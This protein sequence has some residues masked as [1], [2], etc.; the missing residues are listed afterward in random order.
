MPLTLKVFKGDAMVA[1]KDYDRDIIKIGRL[2]SAHLCLDDDKV[3]R[4]H[5]VIEVAPDGKLSIIDMGSVEGTWVNGRRVSKG[6]LSFGDEIRVGNTLIKVEDGATAKAAAALAAAAQTPASSSVPARANGNG[7]SPAAALSGA[8]RA[9]PVASVA[10]A[11]AP[12]T[13]AAAPAPVAAP[14]A[15]APVA[16]SPAPVV[17]RAP[18]APRAAAP[19]E[20]WPRLDARERPLRR[21]G[22]GPLGLELRFRWGDQILA[23]QLLGPKHKGEFKIGSAAG[24]DFTVGDQRLG[25]PSFVLVSADGA[26]GFTLRITGQMT[27]ELERKG[28]IVTLLQAIESGI[29]TREDDA[30]N[31]ALEPDDIVLVDVGGVVVDLCF[32]PVPPK[33]LVPLTERLD[34]TALNIFLL[35]FFFAGL[36][37]VAAV[38]RAASGEEF[39]DELSGNTAV[40]T[41]LL[42][43]P[44]EMQKNPFIEQLNKAKEKGEA[45]AAF[46]G[47]EGQMGKKNAP[48]RDAKASPKAI[49]PNS[50]DQARLIAQRIFGGKGNAGIATLFGRAGL[51]GSLQAAMGHMTGSTVG[52][53]GGVLGM[54]LKGSGGGGGGTG[55]TIGIGAVGTRGVAGGEGK[56]GTGIG[57][58]KKTSADISITQSDPEVQGSMDPELIRRVVRS[59]HDQ[60]KYCYDNAL[61]RNPKLTGKVSIRWII[62]EAGTVASSNVVSSTTNT[63]DLDRCIAG[64]VLTWIFPKPK[65]GGVAVVTYP[66]VFK[67]AGE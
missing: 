64:R 45:P 62:T 52:D 26:G 40:L 55:N 14:V 6:V 24:V 31:I 25:A 49:D 17:A 58:G 46:Q 42:V 61:T 34:W 19:E 21:K 67:Q 44:P 29:A 38:T 33:V 9:V 22:A 48:N 37:V 5:S 18:V 15:R 47:T 23:E 30:Y 59:H 56:Y 60:L 39:T 50:K 8:A 13:P 35:V 27:G 4:I 11:I 65:G 3:S 53:A 63:P 16:P 66:F 57:M 36:L 2:A 1:A 10:P 12:L 43:K 51:G 28:R 32:Q 20:A 7:L 54:G 41:K